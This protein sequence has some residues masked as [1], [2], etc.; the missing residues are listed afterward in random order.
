MAFSLHRRIPGK[1][2]ANPLECHHYWQPI[3]LFIPF[4]P[5]LTS[6]FQQF[7]F[8]V[9]LLLRS[10]R[11]YNRNTLHGFAE[12]ESSE[13]EWKASKVLGVRGGL[14]SLWKAMAHLKFWPQH[15]SN[16]WGCALIFVPGG[17]FSCPVVSSSFWSSVS[18]GYNGSTFNRDSCLTSV[19]WLEGTGMVEGIWA[20]T[21]RW[22]LVPVLDFKLDL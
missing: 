5:C 18:V 17:L 4:Y 15:W 3:P 2:S 11:V 10:N 12:T 16:R 14:P 19:L 22:L 6:S 20:M 9:S 7:L 1:A 21:G 13:W 8:S